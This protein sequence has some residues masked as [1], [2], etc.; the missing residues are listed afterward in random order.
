MRSNV[1]YAAAVAIVGL[2]LAG[3]GGATKTVTVPAPTASS[4]SAAAPA[5]TPTVI[6]QSASTSLNVTYVTSEPFDVEPGEQKGGFATCPSGQVAIGGGGY[7]SSADVAQNID[8]SIPRKASGSEV[9]NEWAAW[10]NNGTSSSNS[11][12]VYAV[13]IPAHATVSPSFVEH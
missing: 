10:F 4:T 3:C 12:V 2:A 5:T 6:Q 8:A 9:P 7:G 1:R 13:C 11:F